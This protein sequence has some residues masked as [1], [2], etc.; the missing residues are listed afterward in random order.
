MTG[1]RSEVITGEEFAGICYSVPRSLVDI[2]PNTSLFSSGDSSRVLYFE[3]EA[4]K[5]RAKALRRV[6]DIA[7]RYK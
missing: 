6:S 2:I 7:G 1:K 4:I 3:E 5:A